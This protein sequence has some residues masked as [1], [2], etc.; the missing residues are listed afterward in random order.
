MFLQGCAGLIQG[1]KE[2]AP[3]AEISQGEGSFLVRKG[4]PGIVIGVPYGARDENTDAIGSDLARLTGFGLVV[5]KR[6]SSPD[7]D[8]RGFDATRAQVTPV[9]LQREI[10]V[11]EA[12]Q[13]HVAEASQGPLGLYVEVHGTGRGGSAERVEI[14]TVGLSRDD[15]WRLGTLFELIRDSR[16][17][18]PTAPRLEVQV[19]ALDRASST[20]SAASQGGM[21]A[22]A[23]R[24]LH[25]DLPQAARTAYRDAYTGVLGAFL[26]ESVT[27]LVPKGR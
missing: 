10:R 6:V 2:E 13:R 20:S 16:L 18:D 21:L 25:I 12:Y 4:R 23:P 22:A 19:Q 24:A 1:K 15:V 9:G 8:G 14:T 3:P 11:D 7:P 27:F 5:V 17:N 26:S